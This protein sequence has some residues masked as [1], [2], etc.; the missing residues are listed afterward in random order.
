MCRSRPPRMNN[1][2]FYPYNV[3]SHT[4]KATSGKKSEWFA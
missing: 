4:A 3:P 2:M 1:T